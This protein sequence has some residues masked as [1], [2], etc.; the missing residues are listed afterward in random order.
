MRL[1]I[2][3][4]LVSPEIVIVY[5]QLIH[6][7]L[8]WSLNHRIPSGKCSRKWLRTDANASASPNSRCTREMRMP[9]GSE[10]LLI[11]S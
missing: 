11:F 3:C 7:T 6:T 8:R 4:P 10:A 1:L 2:L 5:P 9:P